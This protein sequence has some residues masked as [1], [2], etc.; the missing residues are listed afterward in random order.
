[1]SKERII[2]N[3]DYVTE[4]ESTWLEELFT[5]PEVYILN[6]FSTDGSEGY[7]NKYVQPVNI[8][9]SSYIKQ[10]KANDRLLQYTIQIERSKNRVIQ[11]A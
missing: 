1:M 11:N 8:M 3:S 9:S 2:L 10:T 5:S 7:I 4:S 6:K